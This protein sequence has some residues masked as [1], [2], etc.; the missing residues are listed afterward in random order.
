MDIRKAVITAAGKSQRQ[1]P[2]QS[3]VDRDGQTKSALAIIIEEVLSAGIESI[4]VVISP[5]DSAAFRAAAGPHAERLTFIQQTQAL[6]YA[7]AVHCAAAFTGG[8]AFLLLVGD[9]LYLS[10]TGQGCAAQLV[11]LAR[12]EKCAISA[13][14]STHESQLAYYGAVGGKLV[15]ATRR[16]YQVDTVLEKPTPT[17]A[18]QKLTVPG[19]RAGYYLCFFGMHVLTPAVQRILGELLAAAKGHETS[20]NFRAVVA[21]L[22]TQERYL[23]CELEGRRYDF[24]VKYGLLTAQL[25][26]AL[27]G[28]DRDEVLRGL[29]ETVASGK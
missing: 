23:A 21:R 11:A 15:D 25:A 20:V 9:H 19:L 18:E 16:L 17:E 14:Q 13:V 6:G 22:T 24:G 8:D 29:V 2:L 26:L 12:A 4:A 3:L 27:S 28:T 10:H 1:L 7:H 5:G